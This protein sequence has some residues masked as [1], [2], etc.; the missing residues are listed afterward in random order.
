MWRGATLRSGGGFAE[1]AE[2]HWQRGATMKTLLKERDVLSEISSRPLSAA[3]IATTGIDHRPCCD[4]GT[5]CE[6]GA[7]KSL[8]SSQRT[9]SSGIALFRITY[10]HVES[11]SY[12]QEASASVTL[13][14]FLFC[15]VGDRNGLFEVN[16]KKKIPCGGSLT[17]RRLSARVITLAAHR[18]KPLRSGTSLQHDRRIMVEI[19]P[20]LRDL[21]LG[22]DVDFMAQNVFTDPIHRQSPSL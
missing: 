3:M 7:W 21:N 12:W 20:S 13:C 18:A 19:Y 22:F 14:V 5:F 16:K 4:R 17:Y 15:V 10:L 9:D 11:A 6:R 8:P 2:P 1:E